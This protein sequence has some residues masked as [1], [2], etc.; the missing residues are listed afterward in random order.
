LLALNS[1]TCTYSKNVAAYR[2]P[3]MTLNIF[4]KAAC[5]LKIVPKA[6]MTCRTLEKDNRKRNSGAAFGTILELVNVLIEANRNFVFIS[7]F[8]KAT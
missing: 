7:F 8:N 6:A 4:T 2:K 3:T 1:V 5:I